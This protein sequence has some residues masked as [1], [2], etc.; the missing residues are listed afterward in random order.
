M[1]QQL[2]AELF[3]SLQERGKFS[4]RYFDDEGECNLKFVVNKN[5][6]AILMI[7]QEIKNSMQHLFLSAWK[8]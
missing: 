7:P 1:A 8:Q 3:A 2:Q 5:A 4:G 6:S